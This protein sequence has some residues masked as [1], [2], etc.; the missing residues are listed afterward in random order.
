MSKQKPTREQSRETAKEFWLKGTPDAEHDYA[1][2]KGVPTNGTRVYD[3]ILQI[4]GYDAEKQL[5]T[6][7]RIYPNGKKLFLS[8]TIAKGAYY[9]VGK[10][11]DGVLYICEGWATGMSIHAATGHAVAVA[12]SSSN[13]GEVAKLMR[14]KFPE[15]TLVIAADNDPNG[16]AIKKAEE[17]ALKYDAL[18]V[19]PEFADD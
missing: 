11:T 1:D 9:A 16:D 18:V 4:P 17:A 7:L 19:V 13:L 14:E 5:C 2:E 10:P 12:F 3:E 8:G 6:V 15:I